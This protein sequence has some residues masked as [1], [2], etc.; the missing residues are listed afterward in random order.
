MLLTDRVALVSGAVACSAGCPLPH[1]EQATTADL[2]HGGA[3]IATVAA[4]VLAMVAIVLTPGAPTVL[5]RMASVAAGVALP[6]SAV[7]ALALVTV[8][9]GGLIAALERLLLLVCVLW[10]VATATAV[11]LR[12]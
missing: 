11:A 5:R 7:T 4:I 8:G 2:V 12:R 10:G 1:Y 9:R 3:S 6:L